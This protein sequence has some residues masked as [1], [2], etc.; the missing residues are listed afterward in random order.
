MSE[1]SEDVL[2]FHTRW[3]R[4]TTWRDWLMAIAFVAV[5]LALIALA[6]VVASTIFVFAIIVGIVAAIVGFIS[7][8]LG[9]LEARRP[10]PA[11]ERRRIE[12][13]SD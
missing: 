13:A 7:Y 12:N 8:V 9:R 6:V 3:S 1:R 2:I 11:P 4:P 5:V 10:A